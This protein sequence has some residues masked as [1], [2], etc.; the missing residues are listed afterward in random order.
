MSPESKSMYKLNIN[1]V[2]QDGMLK[3]AFQYNMRQYCKQTISSF[4]HSYRRCLVSIIDHCIS[5]YAEKKKTTLTPS[6]VGDKN[7]SIEDLEYMS[8]FID[9]V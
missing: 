6:D 5:Q 4:A 9:A 7:I 1:A 8:E 2:I 3:V